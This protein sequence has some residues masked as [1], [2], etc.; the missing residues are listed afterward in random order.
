M[1]NVNE[2]AAA[3]GRKEI[4]EAVGVGVT[5]VSNAVR[6]EKRFPASWFMAC[7]LLGQAKGVEV[8]P[9]LFGMK[10]AQSTFCENSA[11]TDSTNAA[12]TTG[13]AA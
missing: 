5:A 13:G 1:M 4:A 9:L 2:L 8:P 11:N 3:L 10:I 12:D 7:S 6:R